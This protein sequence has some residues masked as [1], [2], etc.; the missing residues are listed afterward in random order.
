MNRE[1]HF[2]HQAA[3]LGGLAALSS[4][5][6]FAR[7]LLIA[8]RFGASAATDAYLVA[9]SVPMLIYALFFGSGLNVSLVPRL[10]QLYQRDAGAAE[11]V[12]AQFAGGA[13][14]ASAAAAATLWLFPDCFVR[15][16][17]PGMA[18]A[19]T[20]AHFVRILSPLLVLLVVSFVFG[21]LHCA[22]QRAE[23]WGLIIP[24]QNATLVIVLL[25]AA[26]LWGMRALLAGTLAG[27]VLGLLAQV[28]AARDL[29]FRAAWANPFRKGEGRTLLAGLLPFALV[30]GIGGDYGTSQADIFLIRFFGSRLPAGSITLL[31]LG[32]K[33]MALP[34]LFVGGALGLALLPAMSRAVAEEDRAKASG[35]L[36]A[37]ISYALL[38]VSPAAVIYFDWSAPLADAVFHRAALSAAQLGQLGAIL[39]CYSGAV[40]GMSLIFV[41]NSHLAAERRTRRLIVAGVCTVLLDAVLMGWLGRSYGAAGIAGAASAGSLVYCGLL[42]ALQ[43]RALYPVRRLLAERVAVIATGS[44]GMHCLFRL[45]RQAPRLGFTAGAGQEQILWPLLL[46]MSAYLG[47]VALYRRRL[48]LPGR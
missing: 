2:L 34:V 7:E 19:G 3:G 9:L 43:K 8:G 24:L 11:N 10:S 48:Q 33:L 21:S 30:C 44:V 17:A 22:R 37:G 42:F 14:L 4:L 12:F 35:L 32:N 45:S 6:G 1:R 13:A 29:N 36:L 41:L 18:G 39:R 25:T 20:A 26:R 46:G 38:L 28:W 31:A 5:L 40:V 15:V 27:G 23:Y 47:W 16:F